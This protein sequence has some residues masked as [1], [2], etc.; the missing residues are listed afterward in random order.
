MKIRIVALGLTL[1]CSAPTA[2]AQNEMT[3]PS[4]LPMTMEEHGSPLGERISGAVPEIPLTT[5]QEIGSDLPTAQLAKTAK[6]R[7]SEVGASTRSAKDQQ[8]YR[9]ISPSVVLI[10]TKTGLGSGSLIGTSGEV[11]TN[12]HVVKGY[13]DV[14][15]VFKPTVEGKQPTR[16]DMKLGHV[17]K[18]DEITDLAL[19]KVVEV[20]GGRNVVRLG[21][22]SDELASMYMRLDTQQAKRGP[23][24]PA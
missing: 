24:R 14:A 22:V 2:F 8:I 5:L 23:I 4:K 3:P 17:V 15:V 13:S 1:F 16:D 12:Y 10:L 19:I 7:F 11:I 18:Y 6:Q 20:P 9:S 21:D